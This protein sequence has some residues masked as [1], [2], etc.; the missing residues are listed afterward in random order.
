[1]V[2]RIED[3]Q[4]LTGEGPCVTAVAEGRPVLVPDL[5]DGTETR[6]PG[7][8]RDALAAGAK[9]LFAFPLQVGAVRLGALDLYREQPGTLKGQDLAD[10]LM[11]ADA[12]TAALLD[13]QEVRPAGDLDTYWWDLSTFY[14]VEVHQATG[15]MMAQLGVDAPEALIRLRAY[16]FA[17]ERPIPEVARDVVARRIRFDGSDP[18]PPE[19]AT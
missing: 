19:T 6:W 10:A 15:M 13:E 11:V 1:V 12:A 8:T 7:F 9:A 16:A 17:R 3:L 5:A 2:Q 4:L 14:R 18:E